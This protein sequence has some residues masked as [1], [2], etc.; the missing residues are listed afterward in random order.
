MEIYRNEMANI[1]LHVPVYATPGSFEVKAYNGDTLVHTFS[2]VTSIPGGYRVTMPFSLVTNDATIHIVWKF[3]YM[4]GSATKSYEN[5]QIVDVVTPILPCHVLN[6]LLADVDDDAKREAEYVVRKIIETYTGQTFGKYVGV[7]QVAGNDGY[8]LVMPQPLLSFTDMNDGTLEYETSSFRITGE[9]WFLGQAPGAYWKI[10]DAPPEEIIDE[11]TS[12]VIYAPGVI[13][14]KDFS[15]REIYTITGQ[16]GYESVPVAVM[17]AAK[18][19]IG[20]YACSDAAY[21]DK[22]L[23]SMK[24]ADWRIEFNQMAFDGTGNLKADQLLEPYKLTNMVV[25]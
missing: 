14:K 18:I 9:G 21:R 11:F 22:Y 5:R 3:N 19:L 23:H 2:S 10:K 17:Q 7:R 12:G 15:F 8:R 20:E 6:E 16:W 25:I 1:D 24:S 13:K 4:E